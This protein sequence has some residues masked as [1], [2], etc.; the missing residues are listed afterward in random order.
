[1]ALLEELEKLINNVK[2][3]KGEEMQDK[4]D[5]K[6]VENEK[7]D[8]RKLIDEVGGILKGK[9]D[10][11]IIRTIIGKMEKMSYDK[12]EAGTSDNK[13][14]KNEG[15]DDKKEDK[16]PCDNED[17]E[18]KADN[19]CKNSVDNGKTD[20]FEQLNKIYNTALEPPKQDV[21]VS[22]ADRLQAAEDYFAK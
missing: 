15:E 20:Y 19:K 7:V 4:D 17:K 9:V 10:D 21:Y 5:K 16:K 12:S 6:E 13:K 3:G 18:E 22:Q 14:V 2:N 11:E 8:K 1:M